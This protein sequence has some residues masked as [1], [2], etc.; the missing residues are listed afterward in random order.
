M[1]GDESRRRLLKRAALAALGG[2]AGMPLVNCGGGSPSSPSSSA[3]TTTTAGGTT[4]VT[5]VPNSSFVRVP[6]NAA[7]AFATNVSNVAGASS[8]GCCDMAGNA[9][10]W[11]SSLIIATNGAEAGTSV[12]AVRGGSWYSVGTSGRTSYRGEGRAASGAYHSVGFR[13][14]AVPE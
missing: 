10:E 3:S 12:N 6:A 4:T 7:F 14:V 8:Y 2:V 5:S 13:V 1:P 11:T 9:F